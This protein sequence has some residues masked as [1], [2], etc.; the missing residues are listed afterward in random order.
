MS[1]TDPPPLVVVPPG[2]GQTGDLGPIGVEFKLWGRDTGGVPS[3][4]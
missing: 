4:V 2:T 3:V 1:V